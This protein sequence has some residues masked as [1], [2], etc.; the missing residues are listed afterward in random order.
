MSKIA[1]RNKPTRLPHHA[2]FT[3]ITLAIM[4]T[5]EHY[6]FHPGDGA[7]ADQG[8]TPMLEITYEPATV[9]RCDFIGRT[10]YGIC[11]VVLRDGIEAF[12]SAPS[13]KRIGPKLEAQAFIA[14]QV[15]A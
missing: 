4:P 11:A 1:W 8:H 5:I 12:R 14:A 9:S 2:Y 3:I 10:V 7:A 6:S 15:E 13:V